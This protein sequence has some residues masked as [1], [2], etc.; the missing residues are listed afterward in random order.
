M[1]SS[2]NAFWPSYW[3]WR[4]NGSSWQSSDG[5][6]TDYALWSGHFNDGTQTVIG[7]TAGR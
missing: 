7:S 1:A 2:T 6:G 5:L 4:N 3:R